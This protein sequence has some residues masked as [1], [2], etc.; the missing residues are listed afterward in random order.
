M[1]LRFVEI[2]ELTDRFPLMPIVDHQLQHRWQIIR[3]AAAWFVDQFSEHG[4][5]A[6]E[7][8]RGHVVPQPSDN[9]VVIFDHAPILSRRALIVRRRRRAQRHEV[10][11]RVPEAIEH[12]VDFVVAHRLAV[13]PAVVT[14]DHR[15]QRALHARQA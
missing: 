4:A 2:D 3:K 15:E 11:D 13:R 1:I 6:L 12:V 9:D 7:T 14:V 8:V 10:R 5:T